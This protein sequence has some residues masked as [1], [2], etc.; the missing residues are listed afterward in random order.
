MKTSGHLQTQALVNR[1]D[2]AYQGLQDGLYTVK[3]V[4]DHWQVVNTRGTYTVSKT[5][6]GWTCSCPDFENRR[7]SCKHIFMVYLH[8]KVARGMSL[9]EARDRL[10]RTLL[11]CE[12]TS[13]SEDAW[14]QAIAILEAH[15]AAVTRQGPATWTVRVAHLPDHR[16]W[17]GTYT[18]QRL[19]EGWACSACGNRECAHALAVQMDALLR[20]GLATAPLRAARLLRNG[21]R[22]V[23]PSHVP[24]LQTLAERLQALARA[25][26]ELQTLVQTLMQMEVM[27]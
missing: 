9:D 7:L 6:E 3:R 2:R 26:E 27:S 8:E 17:E 19:K 11:S 12:P 22:A 25:V 14:E 13:A 18:V 24:S 1:L 21:Q 4:K 20:R 16:E 23:E 5:S 10:R 15:P